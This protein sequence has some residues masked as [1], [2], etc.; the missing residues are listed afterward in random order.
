[1]RHDP[2]LKR[3]QG[4]GPRRPIVLALAAFGT[5]TL[6]A[7]WARGEAIRRHKAAHPAIQTLS[8]NHWN[9]YYVRALA[10][11]DVHL[12]GHGPEALKVLSVN[13]DGTLPAIPFV[14]YLEW[15]HGLNARRFDRYH[16]TLGPI[17]ERDKLVRSSVAP[18]SPSPSPPTAIVPASLIPPTTPIPPITPITPSVTPT[19]PI[20][21]PEL[22]PTVPEPTSGLIAGVLIGAAAL[23]RRRARRTS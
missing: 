22:P 13:P 2:I 18:P 5:A 17:L 4:P 15:R 10:T 16:P 7:P 9:A 3:P 20:L 12:G 8:L 23:A 1:M 11:H 19:T 6:L 21:S 14:Q